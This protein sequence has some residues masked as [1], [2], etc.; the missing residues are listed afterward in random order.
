MSSCPGLLAWVWKWP[1]LPILGLVAVVLIAAVT[2]S[3]RVPSVAEPRDV[4][5]G[6]YWGTAYARMGGCSRQDCFL[7]SVRYGTRCLP[8]PAVASLSTRTG[9]VVDYVDRRD[10]EQT[11]PKP[12]SE[13]PDN[14]FNIAHHTQKL[15]YGN[16][17]GRCQ[18]VHIRA[19]SRVG[20]GV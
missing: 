2:A 8:M 15:W 10:A 5:L 7:R 6:I 16:A 12:Y 9:Y 18:H 1:L 19:R 17:S 14:G 20:L 3:V 13:D 4:P 11:L